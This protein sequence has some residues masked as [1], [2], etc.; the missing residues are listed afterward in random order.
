MTTGPGTGRLS[1]SET[2]RGL[3]A[4]VEAQAHRTPSPP[5]CAVEI[6]TTAKRI[7]TW[8][9]TVRGEDVD[10]CARKAKLIDADLSAMFAHEME[11]PDNLAAQLAASVVKK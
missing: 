3:L 5:E 8:T 6:G 2:A 1:T 4:V 10:E 7:H 11:E 9:I